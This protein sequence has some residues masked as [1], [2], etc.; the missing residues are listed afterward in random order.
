MA[1]RIGYE[2]VAAV[3]RLQPDIVLIGSPRCALLDNFFRRPLLTG[4]SAGGSCFPL[5]VIITVRLRI[6]AHIWSAIAQPEY[7]P[8]PVITRVSAAPTSGLRPGP[9]WL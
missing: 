2:A 8:L 3:E 7:Q 5:P 4:R 1:L 6:C 9:D